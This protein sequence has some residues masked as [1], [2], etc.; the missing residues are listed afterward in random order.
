MGVLRLWGEK[1]DH[2]MR[3]PGS[4]LRHAGDRYYEVL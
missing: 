1:E 3:L 4:V 2:F